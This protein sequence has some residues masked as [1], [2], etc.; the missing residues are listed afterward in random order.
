MFVVSFFLS[1]NACKINAQ[2]VLY[3]YMFLGEENPYEV[4]LQLF[5]CVVHWCWADE[6][7]AAVNMLMRECECYYSG[8][9]GFHFHH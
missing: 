9:P 7:Q 2:F 8:A 1:E 4:W 5:T 6:N 3:V